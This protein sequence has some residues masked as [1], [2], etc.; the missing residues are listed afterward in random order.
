MG[1][2]PSERAVGGCP[3]KLETLKARCEEDGV[4][5]INSEQIDC[6][7]S[8]VRAF[9]IARDWKATALEEGVWVETVT[10]GGWRF[11]AAW[12]KKDVD[13][14]RLREKREANETREVAIALGS[15]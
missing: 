2:R 15:V 7:Q 6:V 8:D 14:A 12:R 4:G 10:E 9:G 13:T 3:S 1:G 11:V 5:T